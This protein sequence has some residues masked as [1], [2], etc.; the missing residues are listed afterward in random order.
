MSVITNIISKIMIV[1]LYSI[2]ISQ[3]SFNVEILFCFQAAKVSLKGLFV[4]I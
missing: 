4:E 3:L 2:Q 1:I